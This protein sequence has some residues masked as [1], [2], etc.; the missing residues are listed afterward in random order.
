MK[1]LGILLFIFLYF[2][3]CTPVNRYFGLQDDNFFE[4]LLEWIVDDKTGLDVDF[5]PSNPE[6]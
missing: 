6:I 4:E 5:T 2:S 1:H 3:S